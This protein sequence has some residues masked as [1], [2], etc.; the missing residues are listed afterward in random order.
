MRKDFYPFSTSSLSFMIL[1][2]CWATQSLPALLLD[3]HEE[4]SERDI[5]TF[6]IV[7][8]ARGM[9]I[10]FLGSASARPL[11]AIRLQ[12]AL[13]WEHS[14]SSTSMACFVYFALIIQA[15]T[16]PKD[17]PMI[18][19]VSMGW[20]HLVFVLVLLNI[21]EIYFKLKSRFRIIY[22]FPT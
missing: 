20:F 6:A 3:V 10:R 19:F 18:H 7:K 9:T 15:S 13:P 5:Q 11:R 22:K 4:T 21:Y 1:L 17:E 12:F 2:W 16:K 14:G 8:P